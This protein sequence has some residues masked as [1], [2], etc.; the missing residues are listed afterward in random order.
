M[1]RI[2]LVPVE[3]IE[4]EARQR[5]IILAITGIVIILSM[6]ILFL[7]IRI[8][9]DRALLIRQKSLEGELKKYQLIVNEVKQ[10]REITGMLETKKNIIENLMK[11]RLYYPVF[12]EELMKVLPATVWIN[13]LN[14]VPNTAGFKIL[15]GCNCFDN[16]AVA[17]LVSILENSARFKNIELSGISIAPKN[18]YE[19]VQFQIMCNYLTKP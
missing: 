5:V 4:R 3:L 2:N 1:I 16:F 6:M 18:N 7:L 14:S 11:E 19:L 17:D 8:G 12:M 9:V 15:L 10:L 13:S